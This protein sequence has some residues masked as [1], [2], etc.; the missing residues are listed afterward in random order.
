M[1]PKDT[2][3][4]SPNTLD[5]IYA[6]IQSLPEAMKNA[7]LQ[8]A[9]MKE[10][11]DA[12][13]QGTQKAM[14]P[15]NA[16]HPGISAYSYPEGD[17]A[18]PK[19]KLTRTTYFGGRRESEEQL[20]PAEI[21]AYNAIVTPRTC[22]SGAWRAEIRQ[23]THQGAKADLLVW[24]PDQ[25]VDARMMLPG[26]LTLLLLELNGGPSTENVLD[27]LKQIDTLKALL[28][29]KGMTAAELETTLIGGV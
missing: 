1:A 14:H 9:Q 28:T 18:R 3:D 22:R 2:P 29:S 17:V 26:S 27:L 13:A 4:P 23:P 8:P 24:V 16:V 6:L 12:V 21:D 25:T 11:L 20:T 15:E 19:P 7:G 10:M 5:A